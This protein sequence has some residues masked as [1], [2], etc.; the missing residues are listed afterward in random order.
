MDCNYYRA[1]FSAF[2]DDELDEQEARNF[3]AHIL[4]CRDCGERFK[5]F[6]RAQDLLLLLE[7]KEAPPQLWE[8]IEE[9]ITRKEEPAYTFF[10]M[11]GDPSEPL[12]RRRELA[13]IRLP[14]YRTGIS[15]G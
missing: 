11:L 6:R 10:Q 8:R 3:K 15:F 1:L 13:L 12:G 7:R 9:G 5:A 4:K 2:V 14:V